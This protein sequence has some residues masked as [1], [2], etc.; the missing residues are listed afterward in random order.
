VGIL[1]RYRYSV[2]LKVGIGVGVGILKYR[3]IGIGIGIFSDHYYFS[4]L[5]VHAFVLYRYDMR[6]VPDLKVI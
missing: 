6:S 5:P 2:F 4:S 1:G 3:G